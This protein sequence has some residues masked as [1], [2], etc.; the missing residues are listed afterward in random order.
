[1][2]VSNR[3][4]SG[5]F[6][7]L[8][9]NSAPWLLLFDLL[10]IFTLY[11]SVVWLR[12]PLEF[13]ER[14]FP[15]VLLILTITSTF[16]IFLV[17]GYGRDTNFVGLRYAAEHVIA[18]VFIALIAPLL[19]YSVGSYTETV[20]PGRLNVAVTIAGFLCISLG[21]RRIMG[22]S[23]LRYARDQVFC[24]IG[25]GL[26]AQKFYQRMNRPTWPYKLH[27][28]AVQPERVGQ[29]LI[30]GDE[31]SPVLQG[32][33]SE[34]LLH[35]KHLEAVVIAEEAQVLPKQLV[36]ELLQLHMRSIQVQSLNAFCASSLKLIPLSEVTPSWVFD[37]DLR[38]R[39]RAIF[40]RSKRM[41]DVLFAGF[42]LLL[43]IPFFP[44]IALLIRLDSKGPIFFRQPRCGRLGQAF[45]I[46]KFRTM[47]NGSENGS[48]YTL[49][50]DCRVTRVGA[51]LR[52]HRI[53]EIPQLINVLRGEMSFIGPRAE[54]TELVAEYQREI[55]YYEIRHA[56]RPGV[57]GWAQV[58]YPYGSSI[59][60]TREKLSYDLYYVRHY[61][62]F[63]D[64]SIILKTVFTVLRPFARK[65]EQAK[66]S[67]LFQDP[68]GEKTQAGR[69]PH[70]V[71]HR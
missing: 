33:L 19:I 48:R 3:N 30:P 61:S 42:G 1:M 70:P 36:E 57:T 64:L 23:R 4:P 31:T 50:G 28:H 21:V 34:I 24:V 39:E 52:R 56:V 68:L 6:R 18:F 63:L 65:A 26:L 69:S 53:D 17:G 10:A 37:S 11:L 16:F 12:F 58:N 47:E 25:D 29:H 8:Y 5:F 7:N 27:F 35:G 20:K 62:L 15:E 9:R 49:D 41:L 51:F 44:L 66:Q 59:E 45:T 43:T 2:S 38:L 71:S 14:V 54:W 60:D 46:Y 32:G 13:S 55:P 67:A 22:F 40:Q